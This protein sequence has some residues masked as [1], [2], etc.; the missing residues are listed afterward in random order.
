MCSSEP[1]ELY[2]LLQEIVFPNTQSELLEKPKL[3]TSSKR[4]RY[5]RKSN[6][7]KPP[8]KPSYNPPVAERSSIEDDKDPVANNEP[9]PKR[10]KEIWE[11]VQET[12][13]YLQHR[14]QNTLKSQ[15]QIKR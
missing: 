10:R 14:L 11:L 4:P 2:T 9:T 5:K 15:T 7:S 6:Q 8:L 12:D 13:T 3:L 1:T